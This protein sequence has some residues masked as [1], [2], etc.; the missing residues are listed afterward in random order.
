MDDFGIETSEERRTRYLRLAR[1]ATETAAKTPLPTAK[2]MYVKLAQTWLAIADE[3]DPGLNISY[4]SPAES[5]KPS[6]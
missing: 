1:V 4:E 6:A 3:H 5:T 2:E